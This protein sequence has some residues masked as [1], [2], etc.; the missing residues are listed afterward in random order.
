MASAASASRANEKKEEDGYIQTTTHNYVSRQAVIDGSSSVELKGRSIVSEGVHIRGDLA[1]IRM[2]RYCLVQANTHIQPPPFPGQQEKA[3]DSSLA[4]GSGGTEAPTTTATKFLPVSIGSHTVIG[5]DCLI[6]AAAV[7]SLCW[8]EDAVTLGPR[9]LVKDCC[10]VTRGTVI[11]ADT[12]L[13]PFTH[14][15]TSSTSGRL[16]MRLLPPAV[17]VELQ[18]RAVEAFTEFV[19]QQ[20]PKR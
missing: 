8:I 20:A 18:D 2:G 1:V 17:A 5:K 15:S 14:A 7:G 19:Q 4:D 11:P 6:Q 3:P 12:V 10:V 16:T 9:S 13:P